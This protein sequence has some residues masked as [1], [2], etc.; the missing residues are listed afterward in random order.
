MAVPGSI[1]WGILD[2]AHQVLRI[3]RELA[4]DV[5]PAGELGERRADETIRPADTGDHVT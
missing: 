3:V 2:P 5:R 1:A 4:R